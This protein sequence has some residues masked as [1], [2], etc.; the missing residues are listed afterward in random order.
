MQLNSWIENCEVDAMIHRRRPQLS[1]TKPKRGVWPS[2]R[3]ATDPSLSSHHPVPFFPLT[4]H[5]RTYLTSEMINNYQH[6]PF[7]VLAL[8]WQHA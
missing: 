1:Y 4:Q 7:L 5:P 2:N 3:T 8:F 6:H